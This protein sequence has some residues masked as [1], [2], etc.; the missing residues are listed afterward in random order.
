MSRPM[1]GLPEPFF[2]VAVKTCVVPTSIETL[3]PGLRVT[4]ATPWLPAL[5]LLLPRQ[6]VSAMIRETDNVRRKPEPLRC[7]NPHY[8][9]HCQASRFQDF[10]WRQTLTVGSRFKLR[11]LETLKPS[12]QIWLF[13]KL[14]V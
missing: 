6:P 7:M 8:Y 5:P 12:L 3:S 2:A 1:I 10:S 9:C 11:N 14:S 13:G 4:L